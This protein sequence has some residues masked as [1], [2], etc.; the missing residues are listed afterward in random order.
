MWRAWSGHQDVPAVFNLDV[1]FNA[2]DYVHRIGRTGRAGASGL[3]VTLVSGSDARLVG[4]IEKLIKKKIELEAIEYDDDRPKERIND[5]RRAWREGADSNDP[6]SAGSAHRREAREPVNR[7][8]AANPVTTVASALPR[9]RVTR[10]LPSL[11]SPASLTQHPLGA[12]A[13]RCPR[14]AAFRPTSSPSA[15]LRHCSRRFRPPS[16]PASR[17]EEAPCSGAFFD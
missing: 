2:E 8:R 1:P 5:G 3:A 14:A 11:T 7:A 10:S 12:A 15:R 13:I 16:P 17:D 6:R 4:D 9:C